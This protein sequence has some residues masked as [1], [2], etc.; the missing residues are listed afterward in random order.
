MGYDPEVMGVLATWDGGKVV[1]GFGR[2]TGTVYDAFVIKMFGASGTKNCGSN[3]KVTGY[4]SLTYSI[5][6]AVTLPAECLTE[7]QW[8]YGTLS[9]QISTIYLGAVEEYKVGNGTGSGADPYYYVC[10]AI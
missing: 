1:Y 4:V 6:S 2:Y 10:G 3:S 5:N 8:T 7:T 9:D